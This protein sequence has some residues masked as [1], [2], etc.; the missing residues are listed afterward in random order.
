MEKERVKFLK[1]YANL[2]ER[3]REQIIAVV[4]GKT[5]TW[6][7]IYFEIKNDTPLSKK[8]LKTLFSSKII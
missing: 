7:T 2:P 4:D 6:N 1:A 3:L 5:Y 8:L